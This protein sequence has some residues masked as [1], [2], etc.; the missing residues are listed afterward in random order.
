MRSLFFCVEKK[1]L[2]PRLSF[3]RESPLPRLA[4]SG[5]EL[6]LPRLTFSGKKTLP[7][8]GP[9][10]FQ[11]KKFSHYFNSLSS[12]ED[13]PPA[14]KLAFFSGKNSPLPQ[15]SFSGKKLPQPRFA[16]SG[17]ELPPALDSP[18]QERKL[19]LP[20]LAFFR[21]K[22]Y[23]T[24]ST[25]FPQ[26]R[27]FLLP[28][29]AFFQKRIPHCLSSLSRGKT[30][31]ASAR[32]FREKNSPTTSDGLS[33]GRMPLLSWLSFSGKNSPPLPRRSFSL[34]SLYFFR[35]SR[36]IK[37]KQNIKIIVLEDNT[38]FKFACR[39]ALVQ[40]GFTNVKLSS[41]PRDVVDNVK[42]GDIDVL[43]FGMNLSSVSPSINF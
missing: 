38:D 8:S 22:N 11:E 21:R 13:F 17:E 18:F 24:T 40:E 5:E 31:P 26:R 9:R 7:A 35:R 10:L 41:S 3:L 4:F 14:L 16:F 19:S 42:M 25:R 23:P 27:A 34:F 15:L 33:Q 6:P 36:P 39:E 32:L 2:L 12:E 37:E 43:V 20:R 29:L 1:L 28:K 30:P